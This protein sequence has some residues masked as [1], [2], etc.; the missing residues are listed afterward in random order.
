M[1]YKIIL[2][3]FIFSLFIIG[4]AYYFY[5]DKQPEIFNE[6]IPLDSNEEEGKEYTEDNPIDIVVD[7]QNFGECNTGQIKCTTAGCERKC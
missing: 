3:I 6:D 5:S 7:V 4:A 1:G 2:C